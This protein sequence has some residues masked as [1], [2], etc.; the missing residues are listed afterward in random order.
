MGVTIERLDTGHDDLG[1]GPLWDVAEQ[2]LY[3]VDSHGAE[4]RRLDPATGSQA[5]WSVP[6]EIGSMALRAGGGGAVV[7]LANGVH[8]FDF[9]TGAVRPLGDPEA[10]EPRTRFNDGKVDP[11]GRFLTGTMH[12]DLAE[13]L[14]AL[15]RVDPDGAISRLDTGI[16]CSNGPC[17]SPDGRTFYFSDSM[18]RTIY[19]YDY[20]LDTGALANKRAFVETS[21][22]GGAPDGCTVDADGRVWSALCTGGKIGVF[23]PSGKL[24]RVV[25]VPP[26]LVSSVMFGGPDLDILYVTSI[27][28]PVGDVDVGEADGG[29]FAIH[30]L[31]ARG[32]AEPRYAG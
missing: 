29:L 24:D 9:A 5:T 12:R 4:I 20:D 19:A 7:A 17:W 2:A 22:I 26:R 27:G 28:T 13:P 23:L 6:A 8:L 32:K 16:C 3:W 1:E 31:G 15:Y 25:E 30:G 11:R 14:G 21:D 18:A 10:G